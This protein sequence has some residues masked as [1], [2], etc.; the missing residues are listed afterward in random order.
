MGINT[1]H[2]KYAPCWIA[3]TPVPT[4]YL[5]SLTSQ[6]D[7]ETEQQATTP[8]YH[9]TGLDA[10]HTSPTLDLQESPASPEMER[11]MYTAHCNI[12][13]NKAEV[14]LSMRSTHIS[15]ERLRCTV[16]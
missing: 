6:P 7:S 11:H 5:G 10:H 9:G 8:I 16:V 4:G 14:L 15:S 13:I 2:L 1:V 12:L 3:G